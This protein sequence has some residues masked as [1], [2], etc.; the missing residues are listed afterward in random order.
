VER[1]RL[2][3]DV[4]SVDAPVTVTVRVSVFVGADAE[5][6]TARLR[7]SILNIVRLHTQLNIV[8]VVV[9]VRDQHLPAESE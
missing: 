3:G 9:Q 8:D 7:A 1:C 6:L 4:E 2:E 5:S